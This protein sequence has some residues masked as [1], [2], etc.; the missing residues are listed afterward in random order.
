LLNEDRLDAFV[1]A[2]GPYKTPTQLMGLLYGVLDGPD[3]ID[4]F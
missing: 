3:T 2:S 1:V 4:Q